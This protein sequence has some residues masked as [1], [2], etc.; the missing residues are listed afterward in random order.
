MAVRA[1]IPHTGIQMHLSRGKY[2]NNPVLRGM[3]RGLGGM[4]GQ[5]L[6][7]YLQAVGVH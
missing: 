5:I 1:F 4:G 2:F 7:F 6:C 3:Q